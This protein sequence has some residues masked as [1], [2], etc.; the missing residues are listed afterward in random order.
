[1]CRALRTINTVATMSRTTATGA[2]ASSSPRL[3]PL[4]LQPG[5][6]LLAD[7]VCVPHPSL[8]C[9]P[10]VVSGP[11]KP[12]RYERDGTLRMHIEIRDD[13]E[14]EVVRLEACSLTFVLAT[15]R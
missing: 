12:P 9:H 15:S 2:T 11:G 5:L 4:Q 1:M 6:S 14:A 8:R 7:V 13:L 3:T 10:H